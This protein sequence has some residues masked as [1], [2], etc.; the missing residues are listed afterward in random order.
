MVCPHCG[1]DTD[2]PVKPRKRTRSM[3]ANAYY[4]GVVLKI[5]GDELGY[6]PDEMHE[7][8]KVKFRSRIC[9]TTDLTIVASTKTDSP[10]FW[11]YV[12]DIRRWA[13]TWPSGGIYIPDPNEAPMD[14]WAV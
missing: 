3:Q 9:P 6:T 11:V 5:L 2:E 1:A 13:A 10:D 4:W 7:A 12:E 14:D 8:M